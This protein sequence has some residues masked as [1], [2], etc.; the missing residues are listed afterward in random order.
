MLTTGS[1][2]PDF[3]LASDAGGSV[4]LS[5][6]KGKT[7]VLYFYSKDDTTGCTA[8]ACEFR[9]N[10]AA[11]RKADVVVL[12][13]SP[14]GVASH[15]KFRRKFNLPF[16]LLAD[17]HHAVAQQYGVWGERS[18]YGRKYFGVHRTTFVIDEE[19]RIA[20]VF[21]KV[22]PKGHATRVLEVIR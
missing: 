22:K 20:T 19:G 4:T 11:I 16:P 8:E 10:W 17:E 12:G 13:V 15:L 5:D 21:A 14:D 1:R 2:A 6:F 18:M 7:V 9:D 3:T